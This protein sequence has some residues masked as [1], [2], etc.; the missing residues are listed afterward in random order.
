MVNELMH[1]M[2]VIA[3]NA[4]DEPEIFTAGLA[5]KKALIRTLNDCASDLV[6]SQRTLTKIKH[7]EAMATFI[8]LLMGDIAIDRPQEDFDSH[9]SPFEWLDARIWANISEGRGVALREGVSLFRAGQLPDP[10]RDAL[11]AYWE[12]QRRYLDYCEEGQH[13]V[14][15]IRIYDFTDESFTEY[16][17][18]LALEDMAV[19]SNVLS[20][21]R[22]YTGG[23]VPIASEG[24]WVLGRLVADNRRAGLFCATGCD[25]HKTADEVLVPDCD[26]LFMVDKYRT[27][28]RD[29][30]GKLS[31]DFFR[32][33]VYLIRRGQPVLIGKGIAHTAPTRLAYSGVLTTPVLFREGAAQGNDVDIEIVA[34]RKH[35]CFLKI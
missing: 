4:M 15:P 6:D 32:G 35:R 10:L 29:E 12:N 33:R 23:R 28:E 3:D 20:V 21:E 16:G 26:C 14:P 5:A 2:H 11:V 7:H 17:R 24:Q 8:G 1:D 34:F 18:S 30:H 9:A 31:L 27:P 22:Y 25:S 19:F 13:D